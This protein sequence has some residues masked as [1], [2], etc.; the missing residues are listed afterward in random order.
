MA[1]DITNI[2]LEVQQ[3]ATQGPIRNSFRFDVFIK[4]EDRWIKPLRTDVITHQRDYV[5]GYSP[6]IYLDVFLGRGDYAYLIEPNKDKLIV[7]VIRHPVADIGGGD[8][9]EVVTVK[10]YRALLLTKDDPGLGDARP[11]ASNIDDLNQEIM[12]VQFQ[13]IEE[14]IYQLMMVTVGR[15]YRKN[16][17]MDVL[18]ALLTDA[19]TNIDVTD[20]EAIT[21]VD[22]VDGY[23]PKVRDAIIVP[24]G[25]PLVDVVTH[26]QENEGG[27][28]STGVGCFLQHNKWYVYP[29]FDLN[30][31][32][33][34]T[35]TLTVI[36]VP[37]NRFAASERT[38][39]ISAN[40][41]VVIAN[42]EVKTRDLGIIDQ[43]SSGNA[44]RVTN[45]DNLLSFTETQNNR[46]SF[47]RREN[48][49]EFQTHE[50]QGDGLTNARWG[51]ERAT[52]NPFKVF[53]RLASQGGQFVEVTWLHANTDYLYPG[54]P[55]RFYVASNDQLQEYHGTLLGA[56]DRY[57]P[58]KPG[59]IQDYYVN[60]AR[61]LLF[62]NRIQQ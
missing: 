37:P 33:R 36:R 31:I 38:W 30:R 42:N 28:Y 62:V 57:V 56:N 43:M 24:H 60:E 53:S 59:P 55:V 6:L 39:R 26:L 32:E 27:L 51:S 10:R 50:L 41:I 29:L 61:L 21:G 34:E 13:L 1:V 17:P 54:M 4:V 8:V 49:L 47:N 45:A 15:T 5:K 40:Q 2:M 48:M 52:G 18:R 12:D 46:S 19:S 9:D 58:G 3:V 11:H 44:V 16:I 25:T 20:E 22:V 7:D 23:N 14:N 35:R